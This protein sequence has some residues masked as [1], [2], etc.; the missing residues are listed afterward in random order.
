MRRE[1]GR[2]EKL[3]G[4]N[5]HRLLVLGLLTHP[6]NQSIHQFYTYTGHLLFLSLR[7]T[8]S[9]PT[10]KS[11]SDGDR[12]KVEV[13]QIRVEESDYGMLCRAI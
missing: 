7:L 2:M 10:W 11:M 9:I 6:I 8:T 5:H 12:G 13:N 4:M 1:Y 3:P